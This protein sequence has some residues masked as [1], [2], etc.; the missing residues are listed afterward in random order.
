MEYLPTEI[1][2][3]IIEYLDVKNIFGSVI[4]VSKCFKSLCKS[5]YV[6]N[7]ILS[8]QINL[9]KPLLLPFNTVLKKIIQIQTRKSYKSLKFTG[10]GTTG[11]VDDDLS[12]YWVGNLFK[13]DSS[14]YCSR[15]GKN[16]N[17]VGFL[18]STQKRTLTEDQKEARAIAAK[19]IRDH[20]FL[21]KI[22]QIKA[23]KNSDLHPLE[24]RLYIEGWE[25]NR[26]LLNINFSNYTYEQRAKAYNILSSS[27]IKVPSLY[28]ENEN[29][30]IQDIDHSLI[31]NSNRLACIGDILISREGEYS[32]PLSVFIVFISDDYIDIT[33]DI[34][35][36][37]NSIYT[38]AD[39]IALTEM[40]KT[41]PKAY[42]VQGDLEFEYSLFKKSRKDL[43][44][45][46]WGRF[47]CPRKCFA[48]VTLDQ[49]FSGRYIYIKLV[50]CD[51]K[52]QE[53]HDHHNDTNID[54]SYIIPQGIELKF[55]PG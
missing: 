4:K 45:L 37:Y 52:M 49:I 7:K 12:C 28:K 6:L 20:P 18:E 29:I 33:S 51:N 8:H 38:F 48:T 21:S 17:C 47:I 55:K 15:I 40:D 50:S 34:F 27:Q 35:L 5:S 19:I 2:E 41:V 13:K 1:L 46:V 32:C 36:K 3:M 24:E 10:F 30:L 53:F 42:P 9:T 31:S 14:S 25:Q 22:T 16:I 43:K 44:P 39:L 54:C 26:N 23:K 11:G